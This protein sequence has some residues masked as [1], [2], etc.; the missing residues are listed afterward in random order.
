MRSRRVLWFSAYSTNLR[1]AALREGFE[2]L[3]YEVIVPRQR[4]IPGSIGELAK[5]LLPNCW[6]ALTH[7][8]D[9]AAGFK[10]HLNV[11]LPLLIYRLRGIPTWIDVDDLDHEYRTGWM[12]LFI[13]WSQRPFP[14][15]ARIVSYHNPKLKRFLLADLR[16]SED[17][18]L[19]IPQGVSFSKF[20]HPVPEEKRTGVM[21]RYGLT[22]KKVAI[23]TAHLN[24]AS[25]LE[26]V[27]AAWQKVVATVPEAFLLVVGGGPLLVH[28]RRMAQDRGLEGKV[29]FTGEVE[30]EDVPAHVAVA[31]VALLYLSPKVVNEHRCS[32][33]IREYFASGIPVVCNDV[34]E[35][36]EFAEIT[37]QCG[38][39][40]GS[41]SDQIIRVLRGGGSGCESAARRFARDTLDWPAI[42]RSVEPEIARR[43]RMDR[44]A[45]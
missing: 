13:K 7:R 21:R 37:H 41:F 36:K 14:R 15:L 4:G 38:C 12:S 1:A 2:K 32:L 42:V 11:S 10:P 39:E 43:S 44:L 16:C 29:A 24:V 23:Y 31:N 5:S 28:Y 25:D 18:L 45:E 40:P 26:P 17:Q 35:L 30:H 20:S 27:L 6:M 8:A 34:G 19:R 22:G 33:K 9:L 3:G